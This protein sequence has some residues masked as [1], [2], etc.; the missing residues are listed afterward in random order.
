MATD[1][2]A[3]KEEKEETKRIHESTASAV[4]GYEKDLEDIQAR[5]D[6]TATWSGNPEDHRDR[7]TREKRDER[8]E[9][10]KAKKEPRLANFDVYQSRQ[11]QTP[12]E[13]RTLEASKEQQEDIRATQEKT[14][15]TW[16]DTETGDAVI[17]DADAKAAAPKAGPKRHTVAKGES[18]SQIAQERYGDASLWKVIYDI[19]RARIGENPDL[20]EPGW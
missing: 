15:G 6:A 9:A 18:L 19:N 5:L 10:K 16:V 11:E 4:A 7:P 17:I 14:G 20:I 3:R 8:K 2:K 13:Q 12:E 1:R